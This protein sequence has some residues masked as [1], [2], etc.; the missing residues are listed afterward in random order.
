MSAWHI[1]EAAT[2]TTHNKYKRQTSMPSVGYLN[3]QL[4]P[5]SICR[6]MPET[7]HPQGLAQ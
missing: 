1:S 4:Q 5:S 6:P 2:Y 3:P 7:A